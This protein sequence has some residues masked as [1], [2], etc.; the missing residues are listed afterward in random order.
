MRLFK[1]KQRTGRVTL[2]KGKGVKVII[3]LRPALQMGH[4]QPRD[5]D[6]D[7]PGRFVAIEDE[8]WGTA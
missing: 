6:Y 8:P 3:V 4:A 1:R 2:N 7:K 5:A